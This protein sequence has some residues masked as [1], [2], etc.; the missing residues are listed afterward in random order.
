MPR[1]SVRPGC[2]Q[3]VL[4]L[5]AVL[6]LSSLWFF[7][8]VNPVYGLVLVIGLAAAGGLV[9][10]VVSL[11]RVESHLPGLRG[12]GADLDVV[13][14]QPSRPI[15]ADSAG[16]ASAPAVFTAAQSVSAEAP[17]GPHPAVTRAP[18]TDAARLDPLRAHSASETPAP[19]ELPPSPEK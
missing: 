5:M 12:P 2:A 14:T 18:E 7:P 1:W 11:R 13:N 6:Y 15:G 17:V 9:V 19:A 16:L 8:R 10:F 3:F 4:A